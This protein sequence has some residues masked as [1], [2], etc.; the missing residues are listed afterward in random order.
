MEWSQ[1][2]WY[3]TFVVHWY[4]HQQ[5]YEQGNISATAIWLL[6]SIYWTW[7][8][9]DGW[10]ATNFNGENCWKCYYGHCFSLSARR[11]DHVT[12]VRMRNTNGQ[13]GLFTWPKALYKHGW[14]KVL[15]SRH[16]ET[17]FYN[18]FLDQLI[19]SWTTVSKVLD[20]YYHMR[21]Y[22][23][24]QASSEDKCTRQLHKNGDQADL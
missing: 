21:R 9:H 7:N 17:V 23:S 3:V 8:D 16:P 13:C 6:Q 12:W 5:V 1:F 2:G 18:I 10:D 22:L 15:E 24:K 19:K 20:D 4:N 11:M 14:C